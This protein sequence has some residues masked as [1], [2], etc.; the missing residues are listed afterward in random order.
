MVGVNSH[1]IWYVT[2]KDYQI[3]AHT[4]AMYIP[5]DQ[6]VMY[7][8]LGLVNEAGEVAGLAKRI[9]RGDNP[10]PSPEQFKAELGDVLW[11]L[12][13]SC[14]ALGIELDDVAAYNLAKLAS[15]KQRGQI[16]GSGDTR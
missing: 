1:I 9:L 12:A 2:F 11:Y 15:R 16:K 4:T 7:P 10:P 8:T 14:T 5:G 6:P 3:A 13:E